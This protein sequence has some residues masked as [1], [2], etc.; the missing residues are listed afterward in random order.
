M[1][2]DNINAEITSTEFEILVRDYL[3]DLGHELKSFN[4]IHNSVINTVDGNYQ[5][6]I[7]AE[8]KFLGADFRVLI[9]CKKHK[10]SKKREIVQ[11]LFDKLRATGTQ[12]GMIFSTS[13][14]QKGAILFAKKHGIALVRVID[15]K[16]TCFAKGENLKDYEPPTWNDISKYV[17]EFRNETS[18][19]YLQEGNI[20]SLRNF[21]FKP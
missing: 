8:F 6:D 20:D 15:G 14:F 12:K 5:I 17:G 11:L 10:Y 18:I 4:A 16:Y 9:E 13:G 19:S 21:L 2:M 1:Q 3:R 7:F